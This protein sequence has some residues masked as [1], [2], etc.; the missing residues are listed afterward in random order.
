MCGRHC[1]LVGQNCGANFA[2]V[3]EALPFGLL[4]LLCLLC[5]VHK[6]E[7]ANRSQVGGQPR[8]ASSDRAGL[9]WLKSVNALMQLI[10]EQVN[11]GFLSRAHDA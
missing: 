2:D 11:F 10:V 3:R 9:P 8:A 5:L 4:C 1:L 7:E 6:P